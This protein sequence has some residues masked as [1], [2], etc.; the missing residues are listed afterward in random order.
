MPVEWPIAETTADLPVEP[1]RR[2]GR[3]RLPVVR[4]DLFLDEK[5][6]LTEQER[7][8]ISAMLAALVEQIADELRLGLSPDLVAAAEGDREHLLGRLWRRGLLDRA[9]LIELLMRRADEQLIAA[10][11]RDSRGGAPS[12]TEIL[13]GDEDGRV[14]SAAMALAVARGRRRDR[15]GR[16]GIEFDDVPAEEA[17]GLVHLVAAAMRRGMKSDAI[18]VDE[19]LAKAV[20]RLLQRHDEGR[21]VEMRAAA[22]AAALIDVRGPDDE[23]V[24]QLAAEGDAALLAALCAVRAGLTPDTAWGLLVNDGASDAML[25]ARL[26]NLGR[27]TAAAMVAAL[28]EPLVWGDPGEAIAWFDSLSPAQVEA[29]RRWWRLPQAYRD[30]LSNVGGAGGEPTD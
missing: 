9:S 19:A 18:V 1:A 22:L 23:L 28:A 10:A 25:L 6:R 15:F 30:G 12:L 17:V 16:L 27:S 14:A 26:A 3:D 11:C 13:V 8:V 24:G 4:L 2:A 21:R 20:E 5:A 29:A 7:A